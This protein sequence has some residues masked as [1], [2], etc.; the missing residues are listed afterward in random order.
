MSMQSSPSHEPVSLPYHSSKSRGL[1]RRERSSN[2]RHVTSARHKVQPPPR[3]E[4]TQPRETSPEPYSSG[5]E[6]AGE[7]K[8]DG[9][10]EGVWVD[11]GNAEWVDEDDEDKDDLLDLEYHPDYIN[12]L[13]KRRRRWDSRWDA[14]VQAFQTL[15]RETDTTL[16]LLASPSHSTKLHAVTSRSI[17]RE[18]AS[19]QSMAMT[20]IRTSFSN[21]AA[22]R[23]ATRA[24]G[25]SLVERLLL[26]ANLSGESSDGSSE[27]REGDLKRALETALGS[28]GALRGI[29]EQR[30]ARWEDEMSRI[31]DERER[32]DLLLKQTLGVGFPNGTDVRTM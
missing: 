19:K 3:V 14:L 22:R 15:D 26:N 16:V 23:R 6:T 30:V 28:L 29:Y 12:N 32:V 9:G 21:I 13:E 11:D 24:Q 20:N 18:L 4:S 2:L 27:S 10:E 31:S 25:T 1:K 7:E 5:E 8:Y 17:R